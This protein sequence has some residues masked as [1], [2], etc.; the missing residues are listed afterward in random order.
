MA[1][2]VGITAMDIGRRSGCRIRRGRVVARRPVCE[3]MEPR[4][5][6]ST[7]L[8]TN[9]NDDTNANSLRWAI[10]QVNSSP[11]TTA[12]IDF[13]IPASG[14]VTIH[15]SSPLPQIDAPVDIDGASE[16][17]YQG[18]PL[19]EI[20]GSGLTGAGSDGLVL[21]GGGSTVSGLSLVGF[22]DSAIVLKSGGDNIISG[23]ELGLTLSGAKA[24]PNQQGLT[25][26]GSSGNTIGVSTAGTG[27]VISGNSGDGILIEPGAGTNSTANLV[28]GNLI[29]TTVDGSQA[30]PNGGSGIVVAGSGANQIGLPGTGFGNVISGNTGS[31]ISVSGGAAGTIIQNNAIGVAADGKTPLGNQGDGIN[32]DDAPSTL[33]GGTDFGQGNVIVANI[34]SGIATSGQTA[35]L[36]VAGNAIG[37]DVGGDLKLGNLEDGV[38]LGSSSNTIGGTAAGASN[39]IE[40]NG[41]GRVGAGVQLVGMVDDNTILSNSIYANAGLG[42]NL[43]SGPTPDHAPGTPGPNDY[44]NYP[45][46]SLAENDGTGTTIQGTLSESPNTSYLLQF[47]ASPQ[48]DPS[49]YGQGKVL[50]GSMNV[51]TDAN[52]NASFST[53]CRRP[54]RERT[55]RRPRPTRRAIP[56]SSRPTSRSRVRSTSCSR[57]RRHPIPVADGADLTYALTVTNNG[58]ADAHAV[59]L[60]DQVPSGVSI[61][62]V[63]PSQGYESR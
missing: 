19:V 62:S 30:I 4:R 37:T 32:L 35:G 50:L 5:L 14:A 60:S 36:L 49:G 18:Q 57:A 33:I 1:S 43:G 9:T 41:S 48:P 13:D 2:R 17:G 3:V 42:I 46:L 26:L 58:V 22:S 29:G 15:L 28:V 27:N 51:Q 6:L 61:V 31:G 23:N 45:V 12:E 53:G 24:A 52:G 38:S 55:S 21:T 8:V 34:G 11:S 56:R 20:D 63:S 25:L 59:V 39:V 44:E 40:F 54:R 10:L 47:F 7:L 16:P